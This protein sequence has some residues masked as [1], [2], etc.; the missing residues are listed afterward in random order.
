MRRF[1]GEISIL[2]PHFP[3]SMEK[4]DEAGKSCDEAEKALEPM[5]QKT[6]QLHGNLMSRISLESVR[7]ARTAR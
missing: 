2:S 4:F 3:S 1:C 5:W 7:F 6:P